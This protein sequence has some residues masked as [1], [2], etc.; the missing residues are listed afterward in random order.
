MAIASEG[1]FGPHPSLYFVPADDEFLLFIDKENE[2]E[3]IERELST[4]TNFNAGEIKSEKELKGFAN[5][6][7]FPTHGLILR[8]NKDDYSAIKKG[9]TDWETLMN[10]YYHFGK[11]DGM[12][13]VATD[14]RA[15]YNP[16]RMKVIEKAVQK[17]ANKIN[18]NCPQC[19]TPGFGITGAKP[20][21]P[22]DLCG[23]PTHSTLSYIY[24]CGKCTFRKEMKYPSGKTKEDPAYCDICNP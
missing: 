10:A 3:I 24:A 11:V 22:C 9:I 13:Y 19:N 12:A 1:S 15:L 21:L 6:A 4:D 20:G 8:K 17:L 2:L 18:S 23:S 7:L 16:T 5:T 14:M